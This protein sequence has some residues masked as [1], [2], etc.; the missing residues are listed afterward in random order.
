MGLF[1]LKYT[2]YDILD[3]QAADVMQPVVF[4]LIL[5]IT[6]TT[7]LKSDDNRMFMMPLRQLYIDLSIDVV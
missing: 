1:V 5:F 6:T 7:S 4:V 2:S 3:H